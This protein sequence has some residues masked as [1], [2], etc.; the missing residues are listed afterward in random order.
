VGDASVI[1]GRD[2]RPA[3]HDRAAPPP[4]DLVQRLVN[5][6]NAMRGYDLLGDPGTATEWLTSAAPGVDA[7][8]DLAELIALREVL[9]ALLLAHTEHRSPNAASV[10]ALQELSVRAPL[11]AKVT[12]DGMPMLEPAADANGLTAHVLS[13]LVTAP[14]DSWCRLKVC[15]NPN[16]RW[17]FYDSSRNRR[18]SWC[19]M[20]ICGARAKMRTYRAR[21]T[22][23]AEPRRPDGQQQ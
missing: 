23:D 6:R 1:F 13:A 8:T 3:G 12:S 21:G 7:G 17:A 9:R 15:A 11:A 5:T 4:L 14:R 16:C 2:G 19:D 20:N 10:A 22:A 18:S